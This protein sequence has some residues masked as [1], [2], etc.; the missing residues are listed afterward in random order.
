M[1]HESNAQRDRVII[2][3]ERP[4][5]QASSTNE[6]VLSG[7]H[8]NIARPWAK[9]SNL[10][11]SSQRAY[12]E[13]DLTSMPDNFL[14][15]TVY[16]PFNDERGGGC[17][18]KAIESW[19][20]PSLPGY[21]PIIEEELHAWRAICRQEIYLYE[22]EIEQVDTNNAQQF[23]YFATANGPVLEAVQF[24]V[25]S[26]D[27]V[28]SP[29]YTRR[30]SSVVLAQG[31][32]PPLSLMPKLITSYFRYVHRR[33]GQPSNVRTL[34][35]CLVP[36]GATNIDGL[37]SLVFIN[38]I[39]ALRF[40][41]GASS[42]CL[43]FLIRQSGKTDLRHDV[44]QALPLL[45]GCAMDLATSRVL[46][47]T[48]VTIHY[49]P[50]WAR[51]FSERMRNDEWSFIDTRLV[52]EHELRW[53]ELPS[54]WE[55]GCALRSDYVRRQALL[56]ID[57]LVAQ[58][59]QLTLEELLTIYRIQFAV[60]RQYENADEYDTRGR[61]LPN[62]VRK[63]PGAKELRTAR[64]GHDGSSPITISWPVDGGN[65]TVAKTFY[66]PFTKVDREDDY[67]RAWAAFE[68][69]FAA[70]AEQV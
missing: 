8:I 11:A 57:V 51:N 49:A 6:L 26:R 13:T 24:I 43:D 29:E 32:N 19:P 54:Q 35:P 53:S 40:L 36:P 65:A 59:L 22:S 4:T 62:T 67:R 44:S 28:D 10:V 46:R 17:F 42:I 33:Q 20:K 64:V 3:C 7:P 69:R 12:T 39:D 15:R 14:P 18:N 1:F 70:T 2:R 31:S 50:L 68:A 16:R 30:F 9:Y 61:R 34:M 55:R 23:A 48:S 63:D 58:A 52:Y 60:M 25:S 45:S 21:W 66:P 27:G 41:S 47:L 5:F 37:F 56:E 38:E